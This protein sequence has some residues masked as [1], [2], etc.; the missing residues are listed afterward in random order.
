MSEMLD[1]KSKKGMSLAYVL[2]ICL[3]LMMITGGIVSV[4][5]LQHNETG[6]DLN[7]RQAYISAKSGLDTMQDSL[8]DKVIA[9]SDLPVALNGETYYVMYTDS[10]GQ[11]HYEYRTTEEA[12][13]T[14][15]ATVETDSS[16]ELVGGDGTYFKIKKTDSTNYKV[17]A[18]NKTG[19]Y[20]ANTTIN[21]GDLSIGFSVYETF[22]FGNPRPE[23]TA[24][25]EY[26]TPDDGGTDFLMVGMQ[27]A[28]NEKRSGDASAY[29][30]LNSMHKINSGG[31]GGGAGSQEIYVLD[32]Q[33]NSGIYLL[34]DATGDEINEYAGHSVNLG[35]TSF[36]TQNGEYAPEF[37]CAFMVISHNINAVDQSTVLNY[38]GSKSGRNYVYVYLEN[39]VTF[40]M[41][42][43][44]EKWLDRSATFTK[45]RGWYRFY[46]DGGG[47]MF[48]PDKWVAC[49][50]PSESELGCK[51]HLGRIRSIQ[52]SGDTLHSGGPETQK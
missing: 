34:G 21:E 14:V 24:S 15:L 39:N 28:V 4:A 6:S 49:S 41:C 47:Y 42:R 44:G 9:E 40:N 33:A 31:Y 7:V 12:I 43:S 51:N 38:Y 17:T 25:P 5:L 11:L 20:N 2:V 36:F 32:T 45:G 13:R 50:A 26:Y 18:L 16:K 19:K 10:T 37:K 48:N 1:I 22:T 35:Q 27:T 46:T 23:P 8:K 30:T 3:F 52:N 29:K